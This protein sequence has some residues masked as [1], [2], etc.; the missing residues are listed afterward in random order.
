MN[1]SIFKKNSF[2]YSQLF[3]IFL[4]AFFPLIIRDYMQY[5]IIENILLADS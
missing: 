3:K 1:L 5:F 4:P 2:S